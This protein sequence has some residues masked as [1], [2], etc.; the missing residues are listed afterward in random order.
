MDECL[1][2]RWFRS[3]VVLLEQVDALGGREASYKSSLAQVPDSVLT[4]NLIKDEL[5]RSAYFLRDA[6][7][8][9]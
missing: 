6:F 2:E 1:G 9:V 7:N 8:Y 4:I 5:T 3:N